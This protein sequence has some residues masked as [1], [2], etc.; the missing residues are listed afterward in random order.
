MDLRSRVWFDALEGMTLN[1]R[2]SNWN[3]VAEFRAAL[4]LPG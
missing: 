1:P 3:F 4:R 2:V